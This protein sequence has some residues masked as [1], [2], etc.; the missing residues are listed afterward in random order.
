MSSSYG[1][2]PKLLSQQFLDPSI[3]IIELFLD[4]I[5]DVF[6]FAR[7]MTEIFGGTNLLSG[8]LLQYLINNSLLRSFTFFNINIHLLQLLVQQHHP[9]IH[10]KFDSI[11]LHQFR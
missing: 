10:Q 9:M 2:L 4:S 5:H 3:I 7:L 6:P 11:A 8:V 1:D